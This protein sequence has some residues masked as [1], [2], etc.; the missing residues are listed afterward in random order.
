MK[1]MLHF[2]VYFAM[3]QGG[4]NWLHFHRMHYTI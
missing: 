4:G 1:K 3:T 2:F